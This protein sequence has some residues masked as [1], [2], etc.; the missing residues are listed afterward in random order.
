MIQVPQNL[1]NKFQL[2]NKFI[3]LFLSFYVFS[4]SK[5]PSIP[6]RSLEEFSKRA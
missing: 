6:G 4:I 5:F 1:E 3:Y 2:P